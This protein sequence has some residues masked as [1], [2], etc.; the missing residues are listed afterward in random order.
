M[1]TLRLSLCLA[2]VAVLA[3]ACPSQPTAACSATTC[4]TGCCDA[5][6][7]CQS[8]QTTQACGTTGALCTTCF[9]G[10]VCSFGLCQA[11]PGG[12]SGGGGGGT[13]GGAGGG[14]GGGGPITCGAGL[15]ECGGACLDVQSDRYNCGVCGRVCNSNQA[16]VAGQ[17]QLLPSDCTTAPCPAGFFCNTASKQCDPGCNA[18]GDCPQPG[19]CDTRLH[20]CSCNPGFHA[21]GQQCI[22]DDSTGAC[23]PSCLSCEGVS[24]AVPSCANNRCDF[25]CNSG[26]HRCGNECKANTDVASCGTRCS[27][28]QPPANSIPVCNNEQCDFLC[29][30]GFHRCGDQCLPNNDVNSCGNRCSPCLPPTN[31]IPTCSAGV[32]DF[33]CNAGYHRCGNACVP[34]NSINSCGTQCTPCAPPTNASATC[35]GTTCGFTCI[36]GFHACGATCASNTSTNSCGTSCTPCSPPFNSQPTCNGTSCDFV[37]DF[38]Y[39]R[40]GSVC[41]TNSDVDACG[42]SSC[43]PCPVGPANSTRTCNGTSCGW[44]CNTG[45]HPCSGAC[46]QNSSTTQ[47]GAACVTC[48]PPANA[49]AIC[50]GG[51]CDF[52]CNSGYHRCGSQ[53]LANTDVDACG[54][55]CTPCPSGPGNSTRTC[56]GTTC[57]YSCNSGFNACGTSCVPADFTGACGTACTLCAGGN[58]NEKPTCTGGVCGTACITSCN[59]ACVDVRTDPAHCGACNATCGGGQS[60]AGAECRASCATGVNF[61]GVLPSLASVTASAS[62]TMALGDVNA[63]GIQDLVT[64]GSASF[65]VYL[66]TGNGTFGAPTTVSL[67]RSPTQVY[68]QDLNADG[69]GDLVAVSGVA[70]SG[71]LVVLATTTGFGTPLYLSTTYAATAL[72]FGD[73]T[74]DTRVDIVAVSNSASTSYGVLFINSGAATPFGT[75]TSVYLGVASIRGVAVGD[76]NKDGRPDLALP[77]STSLWRTAF[78]TQVSGYFT[79]Q[80]SISGFTG[81]TWGVANVAVADVNNDTNLDVLIGVSGTTQGARIYLGSATGLF[82][83]ASSSLAPLGGYTSLV[84]KDLNGDGNV[85]LAAGWV[86]TVGVALATAPGTFG[87]AAQVLATAGGGYVFSVA[88]ADLTGDGRPELV[89]MRGGQPVAP[90]LNSGTGTFP[91]PIRSGT[92][93]NA[94]G[95]AAGDLNGDGRQDLVVVPTTSS[96]TTVTAAVLNGSGNGTFGGSMTLSLRGDVLTLGDLNGDANADLVTVVESSTA[97]AAEVRLGAFGSPLSLPTTAVP[98]AVAI[99]NV[100]G[101]AAN[102]IVVGTTAGVNY[103]T[104]TGGTFGPRATLASGNVTALLLRDV[105]SDGRVDLIVCTTVG[106]SVYLNVGDGF[107]GTAG[108]STTLASPGVDVETGDFNADGR[109]DLAVLTANTVRIYGSLGNG[110]FTLQ[111]TV[112]LTGS[113]LVVVDQDNDGRDDLVTLASDGLR[114]T[115]TTGVFTFEAAPRLWTV[116]RTLATAGLVSGKEDL[117][118]FRDLIFLVPLGTGSEVVTQ[119]GACR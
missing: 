103:F 89:A 86:D 6:G 108:Y 37:C 2:A 76:F 38:G 32:C 50:S 107:Q 57:G 109:Q 15:T 102:D 22:A 88:A 85:D 28:C 78:G 106:L 71:I 66:G 82:S 77:Y 25:T 3:T 59:L 27:P 87:A 72:G 63:D 111:T 62:A 17:C 114:V 64:S 46:V 11:G 9:T 55:S 21:C 36:S 12:G 45:Y 101:D 69:R 91:G 34:N 81:E 70:T 119:F 40:C 104:Q 67:A 92:V 54:T 84:A 99:G 113:A 83:S 31:A 94:N 24:N 53:C 115:R 79:P 52:V 95:L 117:D 49:V 75:G 26:F 100:S 105:N 51:A 30:A 112:T 42:T 90:L 7:Q 35:N 4:P 65:V 8:G 60:C 110:A 5:A 93:A 80:T 16:C 41:R 13:G 10:Q 118:T 96:G 43:T 39:H 20:V 61:R 48:T 29:N 14:G 47:C 19:S 33:L 18:N 44:T 58:A 116:G 23:G 74:G 56:N 1:I 68:V 97:P 73:F 98:T